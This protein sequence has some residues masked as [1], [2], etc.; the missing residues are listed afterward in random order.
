MLYSSIINA[1]GHI[2]LVE[3]LWVVQLAYGHHVAESTSLA[4]S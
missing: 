2:N 3:A 4:S 1:R